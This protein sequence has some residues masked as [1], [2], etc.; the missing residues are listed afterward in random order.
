MSQKFDPC[1]QQGVLVG[2]DIKRHIHILI[3]AFALSLTL[4]GPM[5][6]RVSHGL[7][8]EASDSL[9]LNMTFDAHILRIVLRCS[10][11]LALM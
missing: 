2:S 5:F 4:Y 10:A 6:R 8:S 7:S 1:K 9:V 11:F 3:E